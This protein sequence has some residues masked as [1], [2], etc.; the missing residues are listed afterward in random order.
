[1]FWKSPILWEQ[2]WSSGSS[3]F[4]LA[5][6]KESAS[7][8]NFTWPA[9]YGYNSANV[10]A[11]RCALFCAKG[12]DS[13]LLPPTRDALHQ[14]ILTANYQAAVWVRSLKQ[15][16]E[17]PSPHGHGWISEESTL[18]ISWMV[19]SAAPKEVGKQLAASAKQDASQ[20]AAAAVAAA[21]NAPTF[22]VA[23]HVKIMTKACTA[24]I[25][26]PR[27][28]SLMKQVMNRKPH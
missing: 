4:S 23:S 19:Q 6:C 17:R 9:L 28:M 18:K 16:Q 11:V 13:T 21:C 12:A 25:C 26:I 14:H 10:N 1:M 15:F 3:F 5:F 2:I 20:I 22:V 8:F 27:K 7:C 24:A